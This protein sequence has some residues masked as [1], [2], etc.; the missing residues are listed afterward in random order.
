MLAA[1]YHLMEAALKGGNI[2]LSEL[3]ANTLLAADSAEPFGPNWAIPRPMAAYEYFMR[4]EISVTK[5]LRL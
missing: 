5:V 1:T 4:T 3:A 2:R